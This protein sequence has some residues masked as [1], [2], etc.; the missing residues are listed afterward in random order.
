MSAVFFTSDILQTVN[1]I[2]HRIF[3]HS[4]DLIEQILQAEPLFLI[5]GEKLHQAIS[6]LQF[7]CRKHRSPQKIVQI[8]CSHRG[9]CV[10]HHLIDLIQIQIVPCNIIY[11]R[12]CDLSLSQLLLKIMRNGLILCT[13]IFFLRSGTP[14]FFPCVL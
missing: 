5:F 13:V 8:L 10:I 14:R 2:A 6:F 3:R 12:L 1:V 11:I 9:S 4:S 7:L